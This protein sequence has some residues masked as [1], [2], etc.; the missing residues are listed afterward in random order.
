[1]K[2]NFWFKLK[3]ITTFILKT[4]QNVPV[5]TRPSNALFHWINGRL[6]PET[7]CDKS[8]C[9][10][11]WHYMTLCLAVYLSYLT[12]DNYNWLMLAQRLFMLMD[13]VNWMSVLQLIWITNGMRLLFVII[14][15][16]NE[17]MKTQINCRCTSTPFPGITSLHTISPVLRPTS[18]PRAA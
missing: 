14:T 5:P 15:Y 12:P 1:M 13:C 2:Q 3:T 18:P 4:I 17:P 10:C 6:D 11:E 16:G 9:N 8:Q 7:I